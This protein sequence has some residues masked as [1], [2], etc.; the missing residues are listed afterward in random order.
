[1]TDTVQIR[2]KILVI[3][4]AGLG[5]RMRV[6][7]SCVAIAKRDNRSLYIVWPI[8][9]DLGCGLED[10]FQ[11]VG[12]DYKIP[13]K[14]I[15]YILANVYRVG[16]IKRFYGIYKSVS[17][18][19][20]NTVVFDGDIIDYNVINKLKKIERLSNK[21]NLMIASCMS[22]NDE[23]YGINFFEYLKDEIN[24]PQLNSF[25]F[26]SYIIN[27]VD[28][29]YNK[30]GFPYI[31]IHIRRTDNFDAIK[32]GDDANYIYEIEKC[33][34]MNESQKFFLATDS[35][36]TKVYFKNKYGQR[37][38]TVDSLLE[39]DSVKGVQAGVIEM[40]LLSKSDKIICSLISSYSNAAILIGKVK[41]VLYVDSFLKTEKNNVL[42]N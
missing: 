38:Y 15:S 1:M 6:L 39:R 2:K 13:N 12:I 11:S 29:E 17:S 36:K 26:N 19:F 31:G 9:S 23:Q 35:E 22:F 21:S 37:L 20:F 5:N 8:N 24:R 18:L 25:V 33:I 3:P 40:L 30:I 42:A 34:K 32:H 4:L 7:S 27:K 10:I 16:M 14:F 41:Q 28:Q